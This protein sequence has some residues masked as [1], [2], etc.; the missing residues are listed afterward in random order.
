MKNL[1]T[2]GAI[3]VKKEKKFGSIQTRKKK[4]YGGVKAGSVWSPYPIMKKILPC[5]KFRK[6]NI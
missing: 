4:I 5:H 6:N 3:Q 2:I 1:T